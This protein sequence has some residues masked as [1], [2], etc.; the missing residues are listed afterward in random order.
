[1]KVKSGL[2]VEIM[3]DISIIDEV[4]FTAKQLKKIM[5]DKSHCSLLNEATKQKT[6]FKNYQELLSRE[7]NKSSLSPEEISK[8]HIQ[9]V[10][11]EDADLSYFGIGI[12]DNGRG[13]SFIDRQKK[14]SKLREE[15]LNS[16]EEFTAACEW[17]KTQKI[18]KN[19]NRK[20]T[21]YGIKHDAERAMNRYI[22]N[23]TLIAAA[24]H[25]GFKYQKI[26]FGI[27]PNVYFNISQTTLK[28]SNKKLLSR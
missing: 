13:L 24:V 2:Q 21:S 9:K 15:L 27:S 28:E 16:H 17:F 7:K 14:L 18:I 4:K 8:K 22:S 5:P 11:D 1:M 25:M 23:G 6:S 26:R 19:F 20:R 3:S 10:L 12:F